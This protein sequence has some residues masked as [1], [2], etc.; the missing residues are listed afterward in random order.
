[1]PDTDLAK[2]ATTLATTVEPAF[3]V[4]HSRRTFHL[5]A[6]LLTSA[7]RPFD[8]E[9]LYVA[10]MLHDIA[11][12]TEHDDGFTPFH[13]RGGGLA[14]STL[15]E[16]G[17]SDLEATL[18]YDAIALHM[19]LAT[20][21]DERPEVAGVHLGAAADVIGLR[22]DQVPPAWLEAL[23]VEHPRL[24]MKASFAALISAEAEKKPYA[25][26]AGLVREFSFLD[27]IHAAPYDD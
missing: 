27:L 18:I 5:G 21:D 12:G 9:L 4:N 2:A 16:A 22:V 25:A 7:Y 6:E 1:V 17:R 10:S 20:A 13:L 14:A 23:V 19:E 24:D 8:A 26:A 11:L 3:L 15:V